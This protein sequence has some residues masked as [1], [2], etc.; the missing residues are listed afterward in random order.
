[1]ISSD[2]LTWFLDN[3]CPFRHILQTFPKALTRRIVWQSRTSLCDDHFPYSY[4]HSVWSRC[5]I[6]KRNWMLITLRGQRVRLWEQ[7]SSL[8]GQSWINL[9]SFHYWITVPKWLHVFRDLHQCENLVYKLYCLFTRML[10][11][12]LGLI[13]LS[14]YDL[15]KKKW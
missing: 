11:A 3:G 6:V 8:I 14:W 2:R 7:Q 10:T 4:D 5:N 15:S 1:M 9:K 13:C 12:N